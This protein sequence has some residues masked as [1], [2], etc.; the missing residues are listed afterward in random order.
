MLIGRGDKR[1]TEMRGRLRKREYL[2]AISSAACSV[3]RPR[4]GTLPIKGRLI[5]PPGGT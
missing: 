5:E 4:T 1:L 2:R 3:V